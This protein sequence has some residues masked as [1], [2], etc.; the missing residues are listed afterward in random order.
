MGEEIQVGQ[1]GAVATND[2]ATLG[3]YLVHFTSDVFSFQPENR[4]VTDDDNQQIEECSLV[5]RARFYSLMKGAPLWYRPPSTEDPSLLFRVQTVLAGD[6][7]LHPVELG[8]VES[9]RNKHKAVEKAAA[10]HLF[11]NVHS[12]LV[13]ETVRKERIGQEETIA[14][15][16]ETDDW[17][18]EGVSSDEEE[19]EDRTD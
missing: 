10:V 8:M 12:N 9:P 7:K 1:I 18:S 17:L 14:V 4:E 2:T 16:D 11:D 15:A 6:L 19:E 13:E 3:Y 5:V